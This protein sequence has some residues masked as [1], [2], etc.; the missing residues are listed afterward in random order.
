MLQM[1][2]AQFEMPREKELKMDLRWGLKHVVGTIAKA[3]GTTHLLN[4]QDSWRLWLFHE[5]PS[6]SSDDPIYINDRADQMILKEIQQSHPVYMTKMN[7]KP[8]SLHAVELPVSRVAVHDRN[9]TPVCLRF[10]DDAVREVGSC[11]VV[12]PNV[13]T[14]ADILTEAKRHIRPDWNMNGPLRALEIV[15]G[16]IARLFRADTR[17]MLSSK[18]NIF[19]HSVRIESDLESV[20]PPDHTQLEVYHCDRSTQQAFGQPFVLTVAPGEL[21]KAIKARIR[22][23]LNVP[24][25]E[26]KSWRLAKCMGARKTHLK[27][28]EPWDS[29]QVVDVKQ[30]CLEHVHPNPTSS[31]QKTSRHNKPLMIK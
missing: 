2:P 14:P 27:D 15:D 9:S 12:V 5:S 19:Y 10:F 6:T 13:A 22:T 29:D 26:F 21:C 25:Q 17:G 11:V 20:P 31:L 8:L 23:K 18:P 30:L 7:K 16:S 3:F 24:D 28:E 4:A 1:S